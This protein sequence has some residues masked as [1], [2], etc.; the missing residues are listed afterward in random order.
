V[1][2]YYGW[3]IV[4]VAF[5]T[6]G[7]AIGTRAAFGVLLVALV[8]AF[9]WGRSV[10]AG[11]VSLNAVFWALSAPPLGALLDRWGSRRVFAGAAV[12]SGLGLAVAALAREPW[13]LYLGLGLIAG[14]GMTPLQAN[15]QGV[16]VANWFVRRRGMAGG[17]VAAG[18]GLGIF[19]LAPLTQWVVARAGWQAGFL[20]LAALFV[21]VVAPLNALLQR[22]RPEDCGLLPDGAGVLGPTQ[23]V[24]RSPASAVGGGPSVRAAVR[25]RRFWLLAVG[26]GI[27]AMPVALLLAHG[28]AI[29]VDAGFTPEMAAAGLG[30]TGVCLVAGMLLWGYVADRWGGEWA[31]TAGSLALIGSL[32]LLY[33]L[34]PGRE[35]LVYVYAALYALG[36][37]S[38][39]SL[40]AFMGAAIAQGR[41]FG[42]LMGILAAHIAAGSALGPA[43]AGWV[44]DLS[45]SYRLALAAALACCVV[46]IGCV[47]LAA[48]RRGRLAETRRCGP[49]GAA[50]AD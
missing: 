35:A 21:V 24:G 16:I 42:A 45:G 1:P 43:L 27:G 10:P 39:Q 4:A 30:V 9:D 46:A 37:A 44:Y 32:A 19:A 38:R 12:A 36:F 29:V 8:A 40:H 22:T 47:W 26:F 11:A 7:V 23:A 33:A 13:T 5:L 18:I 49:A 6:V 48:P 34:E 31:Y 50:A 2:A 14:V 28:V 15:S 20:V 25:Q 3:T 17:I 41:S